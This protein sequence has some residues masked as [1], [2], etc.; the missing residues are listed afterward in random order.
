MA[1]RIIED[2][3]RR[4]ECRADLIAVLEAG[5]LGAVHF[6]LNPLGSRGHAVHRSGNASDRTFRRIPRRLS[7]HR[8]KRRELNLIGVAKEVKNRITETGGD[9]E[10]DHELE[11]INPVAPRCLILCLLRPHTGSSSAIRA[12]SLSFRTLFR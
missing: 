3:T 8:L 1:R 9:H 11:R 10:E 12:R 6:D 5:I 2:P 4:R 7:L